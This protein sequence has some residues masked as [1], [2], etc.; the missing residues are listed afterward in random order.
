MGAHYLLPVKGNQLSLQEALELIFNERRA[1]GFADVEALYHQTVDN[2]HGRLET[3]RHW[4][5]G[6]IAWLKE[7]H[8]WSDLASVAMIERQIERH[9]PTETTPHLYTGQVNPKNARIVN[10]L[11]R[12]HH[13]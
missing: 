7:R 8:H 10:G 1:S 6:D 2:D 5:T 11:P 12:S 4:P 13:P 9:G 3:G